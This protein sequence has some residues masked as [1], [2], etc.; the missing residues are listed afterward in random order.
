MRTLRAAQRASK[1][2]VL[3]MMEWNAS[4]GGRKCVVCNRYRSDKDL[5]IVGKPDC[6]HFNLTP[7]CRVSISVQPVCRKC[8]SRKERT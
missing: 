4:E 5:M 7:Q 1:S 6:G 2:N 3:S 8:L